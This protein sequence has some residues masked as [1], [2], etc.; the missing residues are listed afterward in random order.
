MAQKESKFQGLTGAA[1]E[2]DSILASAQI[3]GNWFVR[4]L[5]QY[6]DEPIMHVHLQSPGLTFLGNAPV[7]SN[8]RGSFTLTNGQCVTVFGQNIYFVDQN[9]VFKFIGK[10]WGSQLTDIVPNNNLVS[11]KDNGQVVLVVDGSIDGWT[12]NIDGSN[13]ARINVGANTIVCDFATLVTGGT[14]YSTND[15]LTVIPNADGGGTQITVLSVDTSGVILTYEVSTQG[16]YT[17][18]NPNPFGVTGGT[19]TGASFFL[20][21]ILSQLQLGWQGSP[22]VAF[23]DSFFVCSVPGSNQ[24]YVSGSNATTFDPLEFAAKTG[25]SA[26]NIVGV[27]QI[28][29]NL[30]LIG[31]QSYEIWNSIAAQ[32]TTTT[33]FPFA[34]VQGASGDYGCCAPASIAQT[35]NQVFWLMQDAYGNGMVYR[36]KG[37]A[38]ERVSTHAIEVDIQSYPNISDAEG[39]V[40]QMHGH[41]WYVLTFPSA[42]NYRGK[43]WVFDS[44]TDMWHE[45][46]WIDDSGIWW[47][48]RCRTTT[49][50]YGKILGGDWVT[51]QFYQMSTL[52]YTDA[53]QPILRIRRTPHQIDMM[54]N[55]RVQYA[56]IKINIETGS[57]TDSSGVPAQPMLSATWNNPTGTLIQDY[58]YVFDLNAIFTYFSGTANAEV[59]D[60]LLVGAATGSA[61]YLLTFDPPVADY[62]ITFNMTMSENTAPFAGNE[63]F[64]IGRAISG[65][66]YQAM[67]TS[68]GTDLFANLVVMGGMTYTV[69]MGAP[70]ASGYYQM[71]LSM[72]G[73]NIFIMVYRT[74]DNTFLTPIATWDTS[75]AM[76]INITDA[77]YRLPGNILIGGVWL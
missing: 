28:Q 36:G 61:T 46:F 22:R 12:F 24:L 62:S 13:F 76:A 5:P 33:P 21:Y 20:D 74:S 77:T 1:Y 6:T 73:E 30:W 7:A 23:L 10:M 55:R 52:V 43:T 60:D 75:E 47:R 27:V 40:R 69:N 51:N 65:Q 29:A 39:Y 26:D 32:I 70:V 63:L 64:A 11:M 14:G 48:H 31:E 71:F 8:N 68:N 42:N 45:L 18:E 15:L 3:C 41:V 4:P 34:A 49:E 54:A 56:N 57:P 16:S 38:A 58:N 53:G 9:N 72:Q 66:G 67:F 19:G 37:L 59:F 25:V 44:T 50:A 35:Q 17:I 2:D